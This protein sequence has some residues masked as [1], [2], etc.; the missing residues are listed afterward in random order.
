MI[1]VIS[2]LLNVLNICWPFNDIEII[3]PCIKPAIYTENK[4]VV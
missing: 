4:N 3:K 1:I 2:I